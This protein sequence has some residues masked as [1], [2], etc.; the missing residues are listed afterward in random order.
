[1]ETW[2]ER[3]FRPRFSDDGTSL[4]VRGPLIQLLLAGVAAVLGV[5]FSALSAA[6]ADLGGAVFSI[7][8]FAGVIAVGVGELRPV[9]Q[10]EG[11]GLRVGRLQVRSIPWTEIEAVAL[12]TLPGRFTIVGTS[13]RPVPV[14]VNGLVSSRSWRGT[15]DA[16][17]AALVV[18]GWPSRL[19]REPIRVRDTSGRRLAN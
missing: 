12:T 14:V 17:R 16:R 4:V 10:A 15:A 8:W 3:I 1:M 7:C 11:D 6:T 2:G 18:A 5:V 9:V 13:G 19:G